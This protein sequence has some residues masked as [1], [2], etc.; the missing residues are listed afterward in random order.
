MLS[1]DQKKRVNDDFARFIRHEAM[2]MG[3]LQDEVWEVIGDKPCKCGV[4]VSGKADNADGHHLTYSF[5]MDD[6]DKNTFMVSDDDAGKRY[7]MIYGISGA[8]FYTSEKNE[9]KWSEWKKIGVTIPLHI[10]GCTQFH[11][12]CLNLLSRINKSKMV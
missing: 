6:G 9:G 3:C 12:G 2:L 11:L 1:D 7:L 4:K 10:L 5:D 8:T